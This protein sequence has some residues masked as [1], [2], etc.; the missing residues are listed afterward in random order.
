[1]SIAA[2][3]SRSHSEQLWRLSLLGLP[4]VGLL[5]LIGRPELDVEWQHHPSH[6]W[7]VLT[8]SAV[9]VALA[10]V[11]SVAA[12]RH[13]DARVMLVSFAFL[14]SAGFLGLHAL[15]TPGVL[16]STPNT[17]F[18]IATPV[19]LFIASVFAAASGTELA[20]PRSNL[21]HRYQGFVLAGLGALMLAWAGVSLA[22]LPP[23]SGPPPQEE[24]VGVL[25]AFAAVAIGLYA[26]A[27]WRYVAIHRERG[28]VLSL[29]V[30]VA[31]VLLAQAV[32]AIVLSRNWHLSWWEW[33]L[34]MLAAFVAIAL[35]ARDEYQRGHSLSSAFGGLYSEATLAQIDRWHARAIATVATAEARGDPTGPVLDDLRDEG[36]SEDEIALLAETARELRRLDTLFG[37]YLPTGVRRQLRED[38]GVARLGG[39]EREISVLFADLASFTTFSERHR[40]TEVIEMLNRYWAVVVPA[41]DGS[42]G[43]V[44]YFAGDGVLAIF[45]AAGDQSD[46]ARRA[47]QTGLAII[48]AAQPVAAGNPDWPIFRVGVNTGRAVVGNVGAEGRRSFTAIGDTTN[49]AARLVAAAEPGQ[50]VVS[51]RTWTQLRGAA[52]GI[53]LG[54]LLVKGKREPVTARVV[55]RIAS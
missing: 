44:D 48:D 31:F 36:A 46:H 34:L 42:G 20:G 45:N 26:F 41:I 14:A 4:A 17:G 40:A 50:V 7:L 6:F 54:P 25:D 3:P 12:E 55:T 1:M 22:G 18:A 15:A 11:T 30:A 47:V 9:N 33:H 13:R 28:D 2:T 53:E 29:A 27:A 51:D 38:P 52:T 43:V 39:E 16:L 35:G 37:P 8:T 19:G 10:Y 5:L 24:A 21:V 49:T 32:L 23:L